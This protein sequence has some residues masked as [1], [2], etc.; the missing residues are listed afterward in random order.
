MKDTIIRD[1]SHLVTFDSDDREL[2]HVDIRISGQRIAEVGRDLKTKADDEIIDGDGLLVLPGLINGH[3]HLYQVGLRSFREL[4]RSLFVPWL[5]DM[6][7]KTQEMWRQGHYSPSSVGAVARAGMVE[8]LLGG[9]TTVADQHYVFFQ[10]T[11]EP[12]VE[13]IIHGASETGI[14]LH[15]GRGSM[16]KGKRQGGMVPDSAKEEL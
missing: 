15:A 5:S 13:E 2:E 12:F 1:I 14:R 6:H 3:Q 7:L 9:V 4:E 16:T 8:S 10:E 11:T